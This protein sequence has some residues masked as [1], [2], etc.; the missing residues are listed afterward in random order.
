MPCF[1]AECRHEQPCLRIPHAE[2]LRD[3]LRERPQHPVGGGG[4]LPGVQLT[5]SGRVVAA[6]QLVAALVLLP[7]TRPKV[8][9]FTRAQWSSVILLASSSR[10]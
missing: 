2:G 9:R 5:L 4:G 8:W 6:R 7:M 1:W 10:G 3:D